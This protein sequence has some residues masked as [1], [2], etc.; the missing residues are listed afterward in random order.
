MNLS[1]LDDLTKKLKDSMA[2]LGVQSAADYQNTQIDSRSGDLTADSRVPG[3]GNRSISPGFGGRA[4]MKTDAQRASLNQ[5]INEFRQH[6]KKPRADQEEDDI[7]RQVDDE[8]ERRSPAKDPLNV[9]AIDEM[10]E[11][12]MQRLERAER[13]LKN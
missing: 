7:A 8:V 5:D 12:E 9:F 4:T 6:L 1:D 13:I 10:D 2:V 11:E 3:F